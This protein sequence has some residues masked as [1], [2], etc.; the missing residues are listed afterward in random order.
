MK[1]QG[2]Q[3]L[4]LIIPSFSYKLTNYY[5][6]RISRYVF[7]LLAALTSEYQEY[8]YIYIGTFHVSVRFVDLTI[9]NSAPSIPTGYSL[10]HYTTVVCGRRLLC[11]RRS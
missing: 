1:V 4:R 6:L 10:I 7:G 5:I 9:E 8:L 11:E 3:E 2:V